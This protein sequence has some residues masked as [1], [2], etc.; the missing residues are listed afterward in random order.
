MCSPLADHGFEIL[1]GLPH[2][3]MGARIYFLPQ[4][5]EFL[6]TALNLVYPKKLQDKTLTFY[7]KVF[8]LVCF[9]FKET[10]CWNFQKIGNSEL[11]E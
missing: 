9:D 7:Q 5:P 6:S 8:L 2:G 1:D 11:A 10:L 4:G 3:K